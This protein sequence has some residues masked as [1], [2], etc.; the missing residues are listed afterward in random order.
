MAINNSTQDVFTYQQIKQAFK[1]MLE[2]EKS[3]IDEERLPIHLE[4]IGDM[5]ADMAFKQCESVSK[6]SLSGDKVVLIERYLQ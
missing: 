3:N 6:C 4:F 5:F 1:N 2:R